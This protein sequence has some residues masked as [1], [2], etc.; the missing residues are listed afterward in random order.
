MLAPSLSI[1]LPGPRS[2][3]LSPH[4]VRTCPLLSAL[5]GHRWACPAEEGL[6]VRLRESRGAWLAQACSLPGRGGWG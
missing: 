1:Y 3:H 6:P 5:R 4:V 2:V